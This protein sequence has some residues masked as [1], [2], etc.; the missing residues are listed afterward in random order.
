MTFWR[1][2]FVEEFWPA[3]EILLRICAREETP[4]KFQIPFHLHFSS[5]LGSR[6]CWQGRDSSIISKLAAAGNDSNIAVWG[7]GS[8]CP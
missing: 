2:G 6:F 3:V 8:V 1:P 5:L 7:W 4:W